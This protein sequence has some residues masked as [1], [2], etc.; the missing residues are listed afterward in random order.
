MR[1]GRVDLGVL[2]SFKMYF[3]FL[4]CCGVEKNIVFVVNILGL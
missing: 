2:V 4:Y 3:F 1:G